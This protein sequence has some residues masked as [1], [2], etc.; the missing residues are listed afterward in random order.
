MSEE[1]ILIQENL[2]PQGASYVNRFHFRSFV[3]LFGSFSAPEQHIR[4]EILRCY[5]GELSSFNHLALKKINR[6]LVTS[7]NVPCGSRFNA[8]QPAQMKRVSSLAETTRHED[9]FLVCLKNSF[10]CIFKYG[11]FIPTCMTY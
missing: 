2:L 9:L 3:V 7:H 1:E 8:N 10:C 11:A 5:S 6:A 4:W